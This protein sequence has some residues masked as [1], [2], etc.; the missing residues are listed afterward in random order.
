MSQ[1]AE[2]VPFQPLNQYN[3]VT[4]LLDRIICDFD[5]IQAAITLVRNDTGPNGK[6]ITSDTA[7]YILPHDPV[8]NKRNKATR[9]EYSIS[10][11]HSD[12]E[13]GEEKGGK[14]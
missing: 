8:L 10:G 3:R 7:A 5:P 14:L 11:V 2:H 6:V 12:K 1:Y 4:Y 9:N 13:R